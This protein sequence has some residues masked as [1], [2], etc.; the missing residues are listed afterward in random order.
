MTVFDSF[1]RLASCICGTIPIDRFDPAEFCSVLQSSK[2][3]P[4]CRGFEAQIES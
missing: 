2:L 4:D 3:G 1:V